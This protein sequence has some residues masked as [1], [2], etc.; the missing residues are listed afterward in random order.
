MLHQHNFGLLI[1]CVGSVH[2]MQENMLSVGIMVKQGGLGRLQQTHIFKHS[3]T[4]FFRLPGKRN[5]ERGGPPPY[6]GS[7]VCQECGPGTRTSQP[8]NGEIINTWWTSWEGYGKLGCMLI[9]FQLANA[10]GIL[11]CYTYYDVCEVA[12][13]IRNNSLTIKKCSFFFFIRSVI[14]YPIFFKQN[15]HFIEAKLSFI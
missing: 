8:G 4:S 2:L 3:L 7:T 1:N 10:L 6:S 15:R 9:Y 11:Y 13:H 14:H 5:G 12:M